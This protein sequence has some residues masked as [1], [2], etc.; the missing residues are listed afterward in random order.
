MSRHSLRQQSEVA[1][2]NSHGSMGVSDTIDSSVLGDHETH[3]TPAQNLC[4]LPAVR[5]LTMLDESDRL[6][7]QWEQARNA[8]G[9][10]CDTWGAFQQAYAPCGRRPQGSLCAQGP[11]PA[12]TAAASPTPG[13][14]ATAA[15]LS[16]GMMS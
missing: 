12:C 8:S 7:G 16:A 2:E 4:A 5:G 15:I 1:T 14:W 10:C 13:R 11:A 3:R 9:M 6:G